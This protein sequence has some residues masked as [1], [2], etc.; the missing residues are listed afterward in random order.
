MHSDGVLH[1][2]EQMKIN[3]LGINM[4]LN[5]NAMKRVLHLMKTSPNQMV[6]AE[7]LLSIFS[8]QHN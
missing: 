5:P 3:E 1:E 2:R 8:E 4:G 7:V 6:S